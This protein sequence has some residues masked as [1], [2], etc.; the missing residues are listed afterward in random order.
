M[1]QRGKFRADVT[2]EGLRE[3][4]GD[5][6]TR[7]AVATDSGADELK[8]F[9]NLC[10]L[11]SAGQSDL[12]RLDISDDGV[13]G[14]YCS[15]GIAGGEVIFSIPLDQCLRDDEPPTWIIDDTRGNESFDTDNYAASSWAK[16]LAA[17][18]LDMQLHSLDSSDSTSGD[19]WLSLLPEPTQLRASLPTHWS[20]DVLRS[21]HCVSLELAVDSAYFA[22]AEAVADLLDGLENCS[23][24]K[25]LSAD[26]KRSMAENALDLVQTRTCRLQSPKDG[27][28]IRVLAPVFDMLNHRDK[29]NAAFALENQAGDTLKP[30]LVIRATEKILENSELFISYGDSTRPG[31]RCLVSYG[32]LP[33]FDTS[34]PENADA[35]DSMHSA[36][37]FLEG[38]RFEVGPTSVP[39]D[40]VYAMAQA[41][42]PGVKEDSSATLTPEIAVRLAQRLSEAAFL[43]ILDSPGAKSADTPVIVDREDDDYWEQDEEDEW[44][45]AQVISSRQAAAL[46]WNQHQILMTCSLGLR[47]WVARQADS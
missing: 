46:R 23:A 5:H 29:P 41:V 45:L 24:T 32:F 22:R 15:T 28:P 14:V 25:S 21:A 31:W 1:R 34:A 40:L 16:C 2:G 9:Q 27:S 10:K 4:S 36:E 39:Q 8:A 30:L 47:D 11:L 3:A 13:R 12:L 38:R 7:T 20:E 44:D 19:L 33:I 6:Q 18:L 37:V 17:S 42:D 43:M 35:D 26:V